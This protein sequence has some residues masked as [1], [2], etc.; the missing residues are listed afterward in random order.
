M[1]D[2]TPF[3]RNLRDFLATQAFHGVQD[4]QLALAVWELLPE[5][6]PLPAPK[7][8]PQLAKRPPVKVLAMPAFKAC[9]EE[10]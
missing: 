3:V 1:E 7:T 4:H 5:G 2:Y 8:R 6:L 9:K 10:A